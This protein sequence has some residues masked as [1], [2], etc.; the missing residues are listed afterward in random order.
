MDHPKDATILTTQ[1]RECLSLVHD[2]TLKAEA[3]NGTN[4]Y[5]AQGRLAAAGTHRV[6]SFLWILDQVDPGRE[7]SCTDA[8]AAVSQRQAAAPV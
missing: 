8:L 2:G 7:R 1:P 3:T 6:L 5:G 4:L